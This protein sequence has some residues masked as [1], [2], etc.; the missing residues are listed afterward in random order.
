MKMSRVTCN[1]TEL[2]K[3]YNEE[4]IV[5]IIKSSRLRWEVRVV[6]MDENEYPIIYCGQT[7]EVNKDV[8]DRSQDGLTG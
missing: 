4:N 5:N 7:L 2:E 3:F 1:S 8:A 6:R